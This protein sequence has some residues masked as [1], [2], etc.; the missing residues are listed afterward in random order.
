MQ[1]IL[2]FMPFLAQGQQRFNNATRQ[3]HI[4]GAGTQS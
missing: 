4:A 1:G 3:V 2:A